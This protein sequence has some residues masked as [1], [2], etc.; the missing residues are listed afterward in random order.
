MKRKVKV[1][2]TVLAITLLLPVKDSTVT[3]GENETA[4]E[5]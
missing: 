2:I 5:K 3:L 4:E 1:I